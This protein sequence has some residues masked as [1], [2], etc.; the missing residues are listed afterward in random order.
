MICLEFQVSHFFCGTQLDFCKSTKGYSIRDPGSGYINN[1]IQF[2]TG[3]KFDLWP[4]CNR[5]D[6]GRVYLRFEKVMYSCDLP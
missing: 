6:F 5:Q 2:I 1:N 4:G 3:S